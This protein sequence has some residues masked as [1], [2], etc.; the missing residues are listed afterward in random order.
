METLHHNTSVRVSNGDIQKLSVATMGFG[1]VIET[2]KITEDVPSVIINIPKSINVKVHIKNT[3]A[4]Q[5]RVHLSKNGVELVNRGVPSAVKQYVY[6]QN[7]L[8]EFSTVAIIGTSGGGSGTVSYTVPVQ[9]SYYNI[10]VSE[11]YFDKVEITATSLLNAEIAV[12]GE[13]I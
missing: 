1:N 8:E 5:T 10:P 4:T 3:A 2:M 12:I 6:T 9:W 11:R 7:D 13:L